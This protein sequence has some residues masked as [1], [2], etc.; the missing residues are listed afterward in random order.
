MH[1]HNINVNLTSHHIKLS[2]KAHDPTQPLI[3]PQFQDPGT[4]FQLHH[5]HSIGI[6][7][8]LIIKTI[9]TIINHT[10]K[11]QSSIPTTTIQNKKQNLKTN[12]ARET[13][14]TDYSGKDFK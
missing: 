11:I 5:Y 9:E 7:I 2:F 13:D 8:Q 1:Y 12:K 6:T 14:E 4:L 10:M 3:S